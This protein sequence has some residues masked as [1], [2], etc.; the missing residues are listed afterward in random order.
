MRSCTIIVITIIISDIIMM[1]RIVLTKTDVYTALHDGL[2]LQV[3]GASASVN[4]TVD[5][6]PL[7][8]SSLK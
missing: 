4:L 3:L 6:V 5:D 1:T 8:D 2:G 7:W